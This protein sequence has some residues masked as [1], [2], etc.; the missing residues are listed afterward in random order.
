M[1]ELRRLLRPWALPG[2][3]GLLPGLTKASIEILDWWGR[4]DLVAKKALGEESFA[5]QIVAEM[6]APGTVF[7]GLLF[8]ALWVSYF[9]SRPTP[10]SE[11]VTE[12]WLK[13]ELKARSW[14]EQLVDK[15]ARQGVYFLGDNGIY[16]TAD[17]ERF[18]EDG[19]SRRWVE[20]LY[21]E[22]LERKE[23]QIDVI[24]YCRW[25]AQL[26]RASWLRREDVK[27]HIRRTVASMK[28]DGAT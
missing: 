18:L 13:R 22:V 12:E 14:S 21:R 24:A 26:H 1:G 11:L 16:S 4:V 9:A 28:R 20:N 17:A 5:E 8:G 3:T 2:Y 23:I 10:E 19:E 27:N 6:A 25:V 7:L 15:W